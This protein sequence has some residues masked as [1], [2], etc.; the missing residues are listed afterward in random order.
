M[1]P[2]K[3]VINFCD[4]LGF[5]TKH[6]SFSHGI[7]TILNFPDNTR[8]HFSTQRFFFFQI[9]VWDNILLCIWR[10]HQHGQFWGQENTIPIWSGKL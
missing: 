6:T 10:R 8:I 5:N 3:A 4:Y 1:A 2:L 9:F 7:L